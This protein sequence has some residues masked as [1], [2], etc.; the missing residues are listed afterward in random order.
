V[1]VS[2]ASPAPTTIASASIW[3][4]NQA[5]AARGDLRDPAGLLADPD[6]REHLDWDQPI[7]SATARCG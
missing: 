5:T 3:S 4:S 1:A 7:A 6:V 2:P